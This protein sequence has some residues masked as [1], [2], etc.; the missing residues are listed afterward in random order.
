MKLG[1]NSRSDRQ[2]RVEI[3]EQGRHISLSWPDRPSS[4]FHAIWLRDN[5]HDS[6]TRDPGSWQK[7]VTLRDIPA[8]TRVESATVNEESGQLELTFYPDQWSTCIDTNWLWEHR[9]DVDEP[10]EPALFRSNVTTWSANFAGGLPSVSFAHAKSDPQALLQWL[11]GIDHY[12]VAMMEDIPIRSESVL[13]VVGLFGFPRQTNQGTWFEI[14]VESNP[15]N[16]A[17]SALELQ[18]HTDNPYR[19]PVPTLQLFGCLQNDADGGES[20]V[21]DG[22]KAAEVLRQESP[23]YFD[24]LTNHSAQF[25]FHGGG[26]YHL[27]SSK[28]MIEC[29]PEGQVVGV[30]FNNRS[31]DAFTG[32]PFDK[33]QAY[34]AAYRR[35]GEL[36]SSEALQVVF[37]LRP[38]Q[39]FIT[40]NTRVLHARKAFSGGTRWMQGAY[41]DKDS[42]RSKIKVLRRE[43]SPHE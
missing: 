10:K 1:T 25:D 11:S 13:E 28:P 15:I 37:K 19:D 23:E 6:K 8:Q 39:L 32:I 22:F 43:L 36:L 29:S 17:T 26:Q 5:G 40:D 35:F 33:M 41:A 21:V 14:K 9:Y 38:G 42:L 16:L 4:R 18:A 34:Y 3:L 27:R 12:G 30:R 20:I 24:L 31:S 2:T 7:L